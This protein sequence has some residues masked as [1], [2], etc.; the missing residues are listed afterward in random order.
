MASMMSFPPATDL[1]IEIDPQMP[2]MGHGS[3]NNVNP[4]HTANG[5]YLGSVNFNMTGA[6]RIYLVIKKGSRT[7]SNKAYFDITF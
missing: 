3:P 6:W 7:I 5:H 2:S 4:V 1:T